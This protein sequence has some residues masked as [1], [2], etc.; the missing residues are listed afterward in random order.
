MVTY[1]QALAIADAWL[2]GSAPPGQ[3]REVRTHEFDLGWVVWAVPAAV[4]HDPLPGS[5]PPDDV[6]SP[7]GVVDRHTGELSTWPSTSLE[8]V[9]RMYRDKHSG[10]HF[11]HPYDPSLPPIVGPGNTVVFTYRDAGGDEM[12]LSRSSGPGLPPP[13]IQVWTELR[14]MGVRPEDVIAIHSDLYPADL[15]GG[16]RGQF[17]RTTFADADLSCSHD[18]GP[19]RVVRAQGMAALLDHAEA[20]HRLS[21]TPPL[22]RPNRIPF[23]AAH[24]DGSPLADDVLDQLLADTRLPVQRYDADAVAESGLP[25]ATHDAL[26]R[27]G[28]PS[29]IPHFFVAD[30]PH[31]PP[32]GGLFCDAATH[33]HARGT[34]ASD[35]TLAATLGEYVRIGSDGGSVVAVR[36]AEPD[37]GT[38]WAIDMRSGA[39]R[40]INRSVADFSH[41]LVVLAYTLP[42]MRG[43]DPYAAGQTVAKFQETLAGIDGSVFADPEHWWAVIVEQMWDGLL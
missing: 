10:T 22:P 34:P 1:E 9:V 13:E 39:T 8:E 40:Y 30:P 41:C 35:P 3:R 37:A 14:W 38:V 6:G 28:L 5:S 18:Y 31:Q 36:R 4:T 43:Q 7:Y 24:H 15:P 33:L 23:P 25:E 26:T 20:A 17:L 12:S 29:L 2:N 27:F 16:Y 42:K 11:P 19:T 21:G 32:A